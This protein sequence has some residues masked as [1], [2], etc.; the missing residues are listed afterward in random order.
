M[1]TQPITVAPARRDRLLRER[2][3]DPYKTKSKLSEPTV[4]PVC[5]AV[6][7]KGRWQWAAS[8][9]ADSHKEICQACHRIKDGYPAGVLTLTGPFVM[10][11]KTE[12]LNLVH[13]LEREEKADHPLHR[14]MKIE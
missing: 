12:I 8:W 10:L 4:C 5:N 11:H 1:K 9:P 7:K 6:F 14:I 13:H 2:I 3:H